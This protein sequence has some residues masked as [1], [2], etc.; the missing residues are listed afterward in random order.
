MDAIAELFE[1]ARWDE[2]CSVEDGN[3]ME[4]MVEESCAMLWGIAAGFAL[5]DLLAAVTQATES[6]RQPAQAP[7]ARE[8]G[9]L[10]SGHTPKHHIQV[11]IPKKPAQR[12][13][14]DRAPPP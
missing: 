11:R 6:V 8:T 1:L 13:P 12:R 7:H 4:A 2:D 10:T 14:H 9:G 3:C 5:A